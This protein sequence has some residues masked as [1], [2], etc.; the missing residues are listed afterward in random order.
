MHKLSL[1][2]PNLARRSKIVSWS[3]VKA[4]LRVLLIDNIPLLEI[5]NWYVHATVFEKDYDCSPPPLPLNQSATHFAMHMAWTLAHVTMTGL[6]IIH[7]A[8]R[9]Y[10]NP[11]APPGK[12]EIK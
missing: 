4:S 1:L 10:W 8:C 12:K 7:M 11:A 3:T 2:Q 9:T 6:S 5:D